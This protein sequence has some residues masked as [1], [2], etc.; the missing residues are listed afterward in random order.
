MS[1]CTSPAFAA[2][3]A[4]FIAEGQRAGQILRLE[5]F[6]LQR[7]FRKRLAFQVAAGTETLDGYMRGLRSPADERNARV[8]ARYF[9]RFFPVKL[10]KAA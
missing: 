7:M 5:H 3:E 8:V 1:L 6:Q 10:A 2:L 9:A 4:R